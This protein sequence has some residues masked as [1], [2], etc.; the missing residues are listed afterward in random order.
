[1]RTLQ[2]LKTAGVA[3]AIDD[4]GTGSSSLASLKRLPVDSLKIHESFVTSLGTNLEEAAIVG[5]V[6][7]LGHAMGLSVVAEGVETDTQLAQVRLLGCDAAQGYL[8]G[9][10]MPDDEVEALLI[11]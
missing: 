1:M 11:P 5:A 2:A 6:V 9:R 7:E 8:L 4:F 3:I 10:P